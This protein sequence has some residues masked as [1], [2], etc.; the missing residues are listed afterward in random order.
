[1]LAGYQI[2]GAQLQFFFQSAPPLLGPIHTGCGA[3]RNTKNV[4]TVRYIV[5][6]GSVHTDCIKI[7]GFAERG[8]VGVLVVLCP[9]GAVGGPRIP[10]KSATSET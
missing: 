8:A 6:N 9:L 3:P 10:F 1:M 2:C 7:K 4:H 5:V